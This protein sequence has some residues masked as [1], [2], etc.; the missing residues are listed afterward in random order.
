MLFKMLTVTSYQVSTPNYTVSQKTVQNCF[1][2]YFYKFPL[3]LTIFGTKMANGIKLCKV[4]L[5]STSPNLCYYT[6][7]LNAAVP[8]CYKMLKVVICNKLSNDL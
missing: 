3:I 6:T 5:F 2:Q 7:V 8:N 4:H 1:C